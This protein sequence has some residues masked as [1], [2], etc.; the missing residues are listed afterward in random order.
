MHERVC[1]A[2]DCADMTNMWALTVPE[3]VWCGVACRSA[4]QTVVEI[5]GGLA[6]ER[7]EPVW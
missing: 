4:R 1:K 7:P 5:H 2:A 6:G 3:L